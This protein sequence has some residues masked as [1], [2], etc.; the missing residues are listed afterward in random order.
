MPSWI[1]RGYLVSNANP[2]GEQLVVI[3]T[4]NNLSLGV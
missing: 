2:S 4:T 3:G 1:N